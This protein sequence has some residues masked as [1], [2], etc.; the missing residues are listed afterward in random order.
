MN[1]NEIKK[2]KN[3][4]SLIK[5]LLSFSTVYQNINSIEEIFIT[6]FNLFSSIEKQNEFEGKFTNL[7]NRFLLYYHKNSLF[8]SGQY[9]SE[10][11]FQE[12][13]NNTDEKTILNN[14]INTIETFNLL[15][16]SIVIHPISDFGF[17]TAGW[18]IYFS[19]NV[20]EFSFSLK[21]FIVFPQANNIEV[22]I[23]NVKTALKKFGIKNPKINKE[24]FEHYLRSRNTNWFIRNPLLIQRIQQSS[25]GYYENQFHIVRLLEKQL[26][27]LYITKCLSE[28][29][30]VSTSTNIF[31]TNYTNNFQT[32]NEHHYFI[33]Y[34]N[35]EKDYEPDCIPRHYKL[36]RLFDTFRLNIELPL[37]FNQKDKKR[38]NKLDKFITDIFQK[39]YLKEYK[40]LNLIR[41]SLGYF[42]RS[43]QSEYQEDKIMFLCIAYEILLGEK[44]DSFISGHISNNITTL[45]KGKNYD[46]SKFKAFYSSRSGIAHEGNIR[47]CDLEYCQFLYFEIIE[48]IMKL[49]NSG[50]EIW[51]PNFITDYKNNLQKTKIGFVLDTK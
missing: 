19:K 16:N 7:M 2:D 22:A 31:S 30:Q 17:Q 34:K 50:I 14:V 27:L 18:D 5:G 36:S 28:H 12:F 47:E 44:E 49:Y 26:I 46:V 45:L 32:Y 33:V 37:N 3:I 21:N 15:E 4:L 1:I 23:N 42:V 8:P 40:E 48:A 43:Y 9:I 10:L 25:S 6:E 24:L 29:N 38:I 20:K 41:R 13:K 11:F 51:K 39:L 35:N